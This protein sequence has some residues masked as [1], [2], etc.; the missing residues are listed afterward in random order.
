MTLS[1]AKICLAVVLLAISTSTIAAH[2]GATGPVK[3]RMTLMK[4]MAS[5]TKALAK[6]AFGKSAYDAAAVRRHAEEIEQRAGDAMTKLFPAGS[7][8][9][10]SEAHPD[11][12]RSWDKFTAIAAEL[13]SAAAAMAASAEQGPAATKAAFGRVAG[14]CK[15]CHRAFRE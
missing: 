14:T 10:P 9:A 5:D 11:I 6:M 12:W 13:E 4:Q 2:S 1:A 8:M 15:A 3:E 7:D